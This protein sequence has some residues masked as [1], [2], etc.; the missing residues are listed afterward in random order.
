MPEEVAQSIAEFFA[1]FP[2]RVYVKDQI[3]IHAGDEPQYVYY[4]VSG[5]IKQHDITYRG[6]DVIVNILKSGA[7][8]PMQWPLTGMPNKYFYVAETDAEVRLAPPEKVVAYLKDNP[9]ILIDL[10]TRVYVGIDGLLGRMVQLMSGS[11][12]SRLIYELVIECQRFGE[13]AED[14]SSFIA[15]NES[16]LAARAGLSRETVSREMQK[17]GKDNLV[18]VSH[19]GILIRDLSKLE[20]LLYSEA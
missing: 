2:R 12:K 6:D 3:I 19:S 10:L 5:K 1:Q 17:I 15:V 7:Y 8:F 20:Q 4:I 14:G 9:E 16:D 13:M 11:A 18:H